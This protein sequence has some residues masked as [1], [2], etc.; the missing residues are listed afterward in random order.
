MRHSQ[1]CE[2]CRKLYQSYFTFCELEK[3][4]QFHNNILC[5]LNENYIMRQRKIFLT[6]IEVK[7]LNLRFYTSDY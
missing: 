4:Y 7:T 3:N 6:T 5:L 1:M 2:L